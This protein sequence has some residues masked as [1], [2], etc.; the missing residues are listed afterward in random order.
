MP[1][2]ADHGTTALEGA[3]AL[4]LPLWPARHRVHLSGLSDRHEGDVRAVLALGARDLGEQH[5]N[6]ARIKLG[7]LLLEDPDLADVVKQGDLLDVAPR[8]LVEAEAPR[9]N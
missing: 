6:D 2:L 1:L 3:V 5:V 9:N 7:P 4:V 8:A